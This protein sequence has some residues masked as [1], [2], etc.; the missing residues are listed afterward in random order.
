M[1]LSSLVVVLASAAMAS[2]DPVT[3][4]V[5]VLTPTQGNHAAGKVVFTKVEGG[6]RVSV[7][8]T[9]LT[10]GGHGFHIHEFGDCSAPDGS[11]A[12][13]HFNPNGHPHS[14]P[15]GAQRHVG[16]LGNVE[17]GADGKVTRGFTDAQVSLE[18]PTGIMGR[19]VIVHGNADDFKTQPT[20]NA[21]G[22][23]ACG[24]VG[25]AQAD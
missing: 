15:K 3:R 14:G 22:R 19:S 21:G 11:S 6:V 8:I 5:A 24:V 7:N 4:A 16:D 20:G 13:D 17:A 2:A 23:L 18:G 9:G 10:E 1:R 25:I 12:G